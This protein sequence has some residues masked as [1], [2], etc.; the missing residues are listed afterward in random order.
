MLSAIRQP[1]LR[2]WAQ[3]GPAR[4]YRRIARLVTA[5]PERYIMLR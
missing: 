1:S 3:L 5:L 4:L 2:P